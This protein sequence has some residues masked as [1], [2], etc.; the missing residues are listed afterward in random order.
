[1]TLEPRSG[2]PCESILGRSRALEPSVCAAPVLPLR[3]LAL[4]PRLSF[5]ELL[6]VLRNESAT[7]TDRPDD[8][9][10]VKAF[11]LTSVEIDLRGHNVRAARS[12]LGVA[13]G[14][15]KL[16]CEVGPGVA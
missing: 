6:S 4:L 5:A 8:K 13:S 10:E 16:P 11:G 2:S 7:M 9:G 14:L 3:L 15:R 12:A 1:M